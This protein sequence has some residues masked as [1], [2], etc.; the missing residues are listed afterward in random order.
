MELVQ[1]L[2]ALER[3]GLVESWSDRKLLPGQ[4]FGAKIEEQIERADVIVMLVSRTFCRRAR[5]LRVR[6]RSTRRHAS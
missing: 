1:E 3:E 6:P 5:R 4:S 2:R